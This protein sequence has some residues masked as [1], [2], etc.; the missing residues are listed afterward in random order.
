MAYVGDVFSS[1]KEKEKEL[2]ILVSFFVIGNSGGGIIAILMNDA[3]L[4][5]PLLVSFQQWRKCYIAHTRS[6]PHTVSWRD[7]WHS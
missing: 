2:G 3:G 4:F 1:K 6:V 5:A 7:T